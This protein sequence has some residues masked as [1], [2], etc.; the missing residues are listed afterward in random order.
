MAGSRGGCNFSVRYTSKGGQPGTRWESAVQSIP[1]WRRR[2]AA[3]TILSECG[4][5]LCEKIEDL[6]GTVIYCD[7][8]YL[9]KG[10]K[11]VHD[12]TSAE[13]VRL[14][15]ALCRFTRTRV[16]VSYYEHPRLAELYPGWQK[17]PLAVSK[18]M[19]NMG[20]RHQSGAIPAPEVLLINRA[21]AAAANAD[22][23]FAEV[24]E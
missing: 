13:H 22:G 15:A 14:A 12:F 20:R 2:L 11:Y 6:A 18:A 1:A 8:P 17:V 4:L 16:V 10:E 5:A 7:P 19:A 23:L 9:V 24:A 21:A 3:V